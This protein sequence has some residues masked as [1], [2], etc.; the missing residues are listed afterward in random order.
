MNCGFGRKTRSSPS[1]GPWFSL[2]RPAVPAAVWFTAQTVV[3]L[4]SDE[5]GTWGE[6]G[7]V[8]TWD[9][10]YHKGAKRVLKSL[11]RF[12]LPSSN[13]VEMRNRIESTAF[14]GQI[15]WFELSD[16]Q[17]ILLVRL[18][19]CSAKLLTGLSWIDE[20]CQLS[21]NVTSFCVGVRSLGTPMSLLNS[22]QNANKMY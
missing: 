21:L 4:L 6:G 11:G 20:A 22:N 10:S 17:K 2:T 7:S 8:T 1:A 14:T 12:V 5:W 15:T 13:T 16:T 18:Q 9:E 19:G 3:L